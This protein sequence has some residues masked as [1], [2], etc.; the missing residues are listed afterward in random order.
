M[1]VLNKHSSWGKKKKRRK[2][3]SDIT[4]ERPL[5]TRS[6][7][8]PDNYGI[9]ESKYNELQC[10]GELSRKQITEKRNEIKLAF[11]TADPDL[12]D[13]YDC[14]DQGP[15]GACMIAAIFN[16][17]NI[18]G[19]NK[20]HGLGKNKKEKSWTTL[21]QSRYWNRLYV[22]VVINENGN[23]A[24]PAG[25]YDQLLI[26]GATKPPFVNMLKDPSFRYVPILSD[27]RE[28]NFNKDVVY[29]HPDDPIRGIREF[30]EGLLDRKIPIA[31]SWNGHARVVIG[32]N[33]S[34]LLFADSWGNNW[35][36][37]NVMTV[38]DSKGK[39]QQVED[40][41]RAGFSSM[42]KRFIYPN[43]RDCMYFENRAEPPVPEET[44]KPCRT[45]ILL[46]KKASLQSKPRRTK[47][48][49]VRK[50]RE[51][52]SPELFSVVLKF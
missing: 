23:C 20:H 6:R 24:E 32:Y 50:K 36:E 16:L 14:L 25:D 41:F 37:L 38:V 46:P 11:P 39:R 9:A 7:G 51:N 4:K 10:K 8:T 31:I 13:S 35:E 26:N 42:D 28:N 43:I 19:K 1:S 40:H 17:L 44:S 48:T 12:V 27:G 49:R 2:R 30:I 18:V 15:D 21:K 45:K 29:L 52:F 5:F 34:K 47:A 33:E 3:R 22:E